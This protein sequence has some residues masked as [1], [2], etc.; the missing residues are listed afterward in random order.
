MYMWKRVGYLGGENM[1]RRCCTTTSCYEEFKEIWILH[2]YLGSDLVVTLEC[3][4]TM[5]IIFLEE[6]LLRPVSFLWYQLPTR[7][8]RSIFRPTPDCNTH[9]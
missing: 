5:R 6:Y 8:H 4:F 7:W 9:G 1:S 3:V 2:T